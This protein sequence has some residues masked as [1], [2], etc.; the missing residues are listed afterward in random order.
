MKSRF[1][2]FASSFISNFI[3]LSVISLSFSVLKAEGLMTSLVPVDADKMIIVPSDEIDGWNTDFNLV[4]TAWTSCSGEPGGVGFDGSVDYSR[5][6]TVDVGG[7]MGGRNTGCYIRAKF[8]L[9]RVL[10]DE[11]D[12]LAI[13]IRFD[14]GFVAYLNGERVAA[15]NAPQNPNHRSIASQA[16]EARSMIWFD[17]SEHVDK[18]RVGDNLFAVHGMNV[19]GGSADFLIQFEFVGR[20]NYEQNFVSDLPIVMISS[21]NN[22]P[23]NSNTIRDASMNVID[24][25][26]GGDHRL[27]SAVNG[28]SGR[29]TITENATKY[30]YPKNHYYITL[31]DEAGALTSASILGLP[32]GDEWILYAPYNDKTLLRSVLMGEIYSRMRHVSSPR[33]FHLFLNDDYM[34]LYVLLEK[35]NQHE[36]R[37]DIPAPGQEGDA[38]TGGYILELNKNRVAPGFD[39]AIDPFRNAPYPVRYLYQFPDPKNLTAPQENYIQSVMNEFENDVVNTID[40]SSAVD[41]FLLHEVAKNVDA[42]RDHLIL[43]K[44]RDSANPKLFVKSPIDFNNAC[45]NTERYDGNRVQGWQLS[46]LSQPGN[47]SSDSMFVPLWW[48]D[49]F[50][51]VEFTRALY[52]RWDVLK[53]DILNEDFVFDTLDSLYNLLDHDGIL[54]FERWPVA[55]KPIEPNAHIGETFDDDYDYLLLWMLDRLDWMSTAM[56]EFQTSVSSQENVVETFALEQ[57]YPNP[58]NPQTTI[59]YRLP[60]AARVSLKVYDLQGKLV[61]NLVDAQQLAGSFK[62]QWD[63]GALPSGVYFYKIEAGEFSQTRRMLLIR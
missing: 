36:N 53:N 37:I 13:G 3:L 41:Y 9:A 6:I 52:K 5:F 14:D 56:E 58:F 23:V 51:N 25:G 31:R 24:K 63:A 18:L 47:V 60:K 43:Y 55:G 40:I 21:D 20:K 8:N 4:D 12:Y 49:L 30:A 7:Q 32:E 46:Y 61:A 44:D 16:Q 57:N 22:Q 42:Y 39:S 33:L 59:S 28:H 17:L 54:N 2:L 35:M 19:S 27:T 62:V 48:Q 1:V 11:I 26:V 15:A 38:L 34:G 45:G 50:E 10:K 29:L